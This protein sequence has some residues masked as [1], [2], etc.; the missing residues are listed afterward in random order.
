MRYFPYLSPLRA[1]YIVFEKKAM[2]SQESSRVEYR[3]SGM[4]RAAASLMLM[5]EMPYKHERVPRLV[6]FA[7]PGEAKWEVR[8]LM[9]NWV[10]IEF[11]S[12]NAR[13]CL[14]EGSCEMLVIVAVS[15]DDKSVLATTEWAKKKELDILTLASKESADEHPLFRWI[16]AFVDALPNNQFDLPLAYRKS[17]KIEQI[18]IRSNSISIEIKQA[19]DDLRTG[20]EVRVRDP[21]NEHGAYVQFA[22]YDAR[23]ERQVISDLL[24]TAGVVKA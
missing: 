7:D 2:H 6:F 9:S 15:V 3:P 4:A 5:D 10:D 14:S 21:E 18:E 13:F 1:L 8:S 17:D 23:T 22:P 16:A 19:S 12:E 11:P 24:T 20:W